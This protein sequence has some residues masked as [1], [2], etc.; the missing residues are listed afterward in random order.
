[1]C[2]GGSVGRLKISV[3][4]R[5]SVPLGQDLETF[6]GWMEKV[7]FENCL[8]KRIQSKHFLVAFT[9]LL[10]KTDSSAWMFKFRKM[11][12]PAWLGLPLCFGQSKVFHV[13]SILYNEKPI[14]L[15]GFPAVN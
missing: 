2:E 12:R 4:S 15:C 5:Q 14:Q 6:A 9:Y 8:F 11:E 7:S 1:M 10:L 13:S 3:N